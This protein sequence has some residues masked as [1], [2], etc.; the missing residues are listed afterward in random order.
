MAVID[1]VK[2]DGDP[3]ALAWKFPGEELSTA[4]QVVVNQAQEA[5]L[6]KGGRAHDVL[7]PG[8]HTLST[9]NIPLLARLVNLPFGGKTPFTAEI[10]YV[11][12]TV[13][14]NLRWGTKSP[15][16]L[17]DPVY[18]RPVN[19]RAYGGW[20]MRV[21]EA[22]PF[23]TQI[24][25]T[26]TRVDTDTIYDYFISEIHQHLATAVGR[27]FADISV[28]HVSAH[29][30]DLSRTV[31]E[32]LVDA[33]ARYGIEIT[34]FNIASF[35]LPPE[36]MRDLQAKLD[37]GLDEAVRVGRLREATGLGGDRVYGNMR[38]F[39]TLEK[40]AGN[41]SGAAGAL[42]STGLGAGV[43]FGLGAV[44]GQN[45]DPAR[46]APPSGPPGVEAGTPA[47]RM[48]SLKE[49]LDAGLISDAEFAA[50]RQAIIDSI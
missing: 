34:N 27:R 25:G 38:S 45:I 16:P 46:A 18:K 32:S 24:V 43:G 10:W 29:I 31:M 26:G 1:M 48:R 37:A 13:R 30:A 49:L 23:L 20:G 6:F 8:T 44:V 28:L 36:E 47:E 7:G 4:T 11:D 14:R 35:T 15:I 21:A 22:R 5:L 17:F 2:F 39:D 42:M 19:V 50:K 40:A 12:K 3:Q 33:F 41:E 9:G